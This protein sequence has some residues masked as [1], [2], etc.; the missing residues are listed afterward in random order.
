MVL[1]TLAIVTPSLGS[2]AVELFTP[3]VDVLVVSVNGGTLTGDLEITYTT[4]PSAIG[5]S[6]Q[7]NLDNFSLNGYRFHLFGVELTQ[8]Q[9]SLGGTYTFKLIALAGLYPT[10]SMNYV[11]QFNTIG[12]DDGASLIDSTVSLSKLEALSSANIIVGNASNQPTQVTVSG[13][14]TISN[15][16]VTTIGNTKVT[17]AMIAT[18]VARTKLA[19]GTAN[20]VIVNDGSG[21]LSE[22]STLPPS[23]GGTGQNNGSATGFQKWSSG[24]SSV[25]TIT[26]MVT[27]QV[28]FESGYTGD[29]K[30]M[31]PC[32]GT[33][34]GIYGYAT[35]VIAG[36]D[37]GT[38]TAKNNAGTAMGSG[39]ITFTASDAR[40]TAYTVNPNTNN[41][42]VQGDLLTFTTAKTTSGGQVQLSITYTRLP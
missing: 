6:W 16:G 35:K 32:S 42:F 28:S 41:T 7:V 23:S 8:S 10:V 26:D 34:T 12:V 1:S 21:N 24:T 22:A 11:P 14:V 20:Y 37:N 29:F 5:Q 19:T 2:Q 39:T 17:N 27:L 3:S 38:I 31:M 9:I 15:A 13:D 40:G 18:G 36:T 33:V 4:A 30:I 25:G